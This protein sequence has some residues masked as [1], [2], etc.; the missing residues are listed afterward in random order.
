LALFVGCVF[1]FFFAPKAAR[2]HSLINKASNALFSLV[3]FY[4]DDVNEDVKHADQAHKH[5]NRKKKFKTTVDASSTTKTETKETA[6]TQLYFATPPSD[7][8][9][10]HLTLKKKDAVQ[11]KKKKPKGIGTQ[12]RNVYFKK[13][14]RLVQIRCTT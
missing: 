11:K 4:R 2:Q 9:S 1:F 3:V 7:Y 5:T 12:T 6:R 10:I 13:Q 8:V 14:P